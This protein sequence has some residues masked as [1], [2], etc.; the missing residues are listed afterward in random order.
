MASIG[1]LSGS[2]GSSSIYGTRNVLS[3]LASGLD[4]ESM[5]ENAVSGYQMKLSSLQQQKTKVEWKQEAYRSMITKMVGF[6][7]KYTSYTSGTNL[8][9]SSF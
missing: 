1:G 5:I 9:S 2:S 7:Q 6:S 8:L 4:T 3:G